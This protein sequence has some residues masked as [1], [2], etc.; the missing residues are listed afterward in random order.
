MLELILTR[1]F[2]V[3]LYYHYA[4]MVISLALLGSG[5]SGVYIYLFPHIF[6]RDRL[7][8]HLYTCCWLFGISIPLVLYSILELDFQLQFSPGMMARV[9]LFYSIPAIPF[10]LGGLCISLAMTH[11]AESINR[12]YFFDLIGAAFGCLMVIPLLDRLG[13]PEAMLS[14]SILAAIACW[15]FNY[16]EGSPGCVG[17]R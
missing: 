13:G 8:K 11:L 12:L 9:F 1:I 7:E 14:V 4:F 17:S 6:R 3:K 16:P 2:S 10:F 5:A 15:L